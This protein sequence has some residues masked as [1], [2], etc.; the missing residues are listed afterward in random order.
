MSLTSTHDRRMRWDKVPPAVGAVG[1]VLY[2]A[3]RM[4]AVFTKHELPSLVL[5]IG[6]AILAGAAVAWIIARRATARAHIDV[7]SD[8]QKDTSHSIPLNHFV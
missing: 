1:Y 5:V 3:A 6:V 2:F 8:R 4:A 7:R